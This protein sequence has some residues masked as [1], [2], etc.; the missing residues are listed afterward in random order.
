MEKL[1]AIRETLLSELLPFC[2][3]G[4]DGAFTEELETLRNESLA[5][6]W[7]NQCRALARQCP[8]ESSDAI[9]V[10]LMK[11]GCVLFEGAQGVLLDEWRGFHPHTTWSS[12]NTAAVE[13]VAAR[14]EIADPIEHFGVLRSFLTRHGAGPLPTHDESL[15]ASL[16][17][18]H[19]NGD[20]WQG[21]F[22][23]GHPDA[24]LLRYAIEAAGKLSG[25]LISH[26]DVFERGVK[27][28]WCGSYSAGASS[29]V[30]RLPLGRYKD[31][32]HQNQLTELLLSAQPQYSLEPIDSARSFLE[33]IASV[34]PLP[35]VMGSF[36][37][38]FES[39]RA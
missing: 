38:S 28:K 37:N 15:D 19:N 25:L 26:L 39:V 30:D 3:K 8:P 23:R 13:D 1:Q 20:G 22:R 21:G 18:P 5:G 12:I 16:P 29:G 32:D 35:V 24:V 31:L 27:L 33:R 7:L 14:F 17:E 11:A 10:Q 34:T 9:H 36:G 2:Q 6:K 4:S